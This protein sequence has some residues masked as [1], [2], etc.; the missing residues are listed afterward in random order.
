MD[1]A[2][3]P[4]LSW[5]WTPLP[6]QRFL[7]DLKTAQ[8][9]DAK[10]AEKGEETPAAEELTSSS[11]DWPEFRGALRD[12]RL[13]G[14]TIGTDWEKSPPRELWRHRIG[15]GW[16]S[17]TIIGER[18]FTQE[19]RGEDEYVVCYDTSKG[20]ELWSYH[21]PVRFYELIAG[22]GP[23]STPTFHDGLIYA[24]GAT[25]KLNCL[26]ASTG[27][28]VW[29]RDIVADTAAKIPM[30]GFSS[31]PL[32][33][34]G[35]VSV[36]AGGPNGKSVIAYHADS[37]KLAWAA[38]TGEMSYCSTQLSKV[39]GV[40]QLLITTDVGL[41]SFQPKT[42]EVLWHH[43]WPTEGIARVVQPAVISDT[44][45]LIGTGMG[46]GTRRVHVDLKDKTWSTTEVW[47]VRS[48]KPYFNDF[49]VLDDHA[50]GFD[51]NIFMCVK[52]EDG[53]PVWRAR[54][55]GNGEVL[56][57][58]DQKL[59]VVL[60]ETGEIV[61]VAAKSDKHHEVAKYKAIEGKTWNHP[62][63]SH[64]KLFARNAEEI[65]CFELPLKAAAETAAV[66]R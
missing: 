44:D 51:N 2:F 10:A 64:G 21:D 55:Y 34:E 26:N 37:G 20:T 50:Y 25:G 7:A 48:F 16:S 56:L 36:F 33:V 47:T 40:E 39:C 11:D 53:K 41:T 4:K 65:A 59:L 14:V 58:D 38:G 5:I 17:V 15:P 62:V 60:T 8:K 22:A 9:P 13:A 31:S 6:E 1:G 54:G 28:L 30:W 61:L 66:G 43:A 63:I 32:V 42:G 24:L 29:S 57:L 18:L 27:K 49:V 52:L 19:Q 46:V 12:G 45:V 23:R 35:L 3:N